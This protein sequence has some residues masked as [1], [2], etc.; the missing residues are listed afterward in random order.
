MPSTGSVLFNRQGLFVLPFSLAVYVLLQYTI[1]ASSLCTTAEPFAP[2]ALKCYFA[3][4][5]TFFAT[6]FEQMVKM[7]I[8]HR[9]SRMYHRLLY[10][11]AFVISLVAGSSN[12]LTSLYGGVCK[13]ALGVESPVAQWGEWLVCVPLMVY[14]NIAIEDK[15]QE[16]SDS[17]LAIIF[18]TSISILL[19]FM[20]NFHEPFAV[21]VIFFSLANFCFIAF[22]LY[23]IKCSKRAVKP[24]FSRLRSNLSTVETRVSQEQDLIKA[25]KYAYLSRLLFII[26]PV[27]PLVYLLAF[28]KFLD[29]DQ[30]MVFFGFGGII[31]KM[32]FSNI[33]VDIKVGISDQI[34]AQRRL[35]RSADE[36]RNIFLRY[37]FH[38][39]R[40]PLHTLTMGM[41][42][43]EGDKIK[44]DQEGTGRLFESRDEVVNMMQGATDFMSNTLSDVLLIHKI[45]EGLF[46]ITKIPFHL[47]DVIGMAVHTLQYELGLKDINVTIENIENTAH[48]DHHSDLFLGDRSKLEAVVVDFLSNAIRRSCSSSNIE[49]TV[50]KRFISETIEEKPHGF[51][52]MIKNSSQKFITTLCNIIPRYRARTLSASEN[53]LR[54]TVFPSYHTENDHENYELLTAKTVCEVTL[55]IKDHGN[56]I[57]EEDMLGLLTP[58]TQI[59]P[60]QKCSEQGR[61]TGLWLVLAK[62]II[63][64]HHGQ[65]MADSNPGGEGNVFG[66]VIPFQLIPPAQLN[67]IIR[68]PENAIG[69]NSS[70]SQI[71]SHTNG[72]SSM[73]SMINI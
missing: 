29:R 70:D 32:F 31:A 68:S 41:T 71:L 18:L 48:M 64:L 13:D 34:S 65:L 61:D 73:V 45:E 47:H 30:T 50:V 11:T 26:F 8:C 66:F 1:M 16:L 60:N 43:I 23:S 39:L 36:S 44:S 20:M 53:T 46:E 35:K 9:Q 51:M 33:L 62:E 55:T 25:T 4:G 28:F 21:G 24:Q 37:V 22:P 40:T 72:S 52:K 69:L 54:E 2:W 19:G 3:M 38:E 67:M 17:D 27:F 14:I 5:F 10:L 57:T 58:Y 63:I 59:R 7:L 15:D 12:L 6:G 56:S 42:V 49:I